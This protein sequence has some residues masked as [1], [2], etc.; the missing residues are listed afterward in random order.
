MKHQRSSLRLYPRER[1]DYGGGTMSEA[2][3][4]LMRR[5]VEE[6]WDQG[7][8]AATDELIGDG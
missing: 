5:Y 2:N 7:S 3:K 1:G 8:M 4:E 6:I